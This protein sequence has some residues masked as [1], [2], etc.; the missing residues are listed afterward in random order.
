V[1]D[2]AEAVAWCQF[3]PAVELPNIHNRKEYEAAGD[4]SPDYRITCIFVDKK[5]RRRGVT[6]VALRVPST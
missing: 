2:G 1:F 4:D 3:G 6:A 5:H